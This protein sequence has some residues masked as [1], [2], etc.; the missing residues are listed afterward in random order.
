M[1]QRSR[2]YG[3]ALWGAALATCLGACSWIGLDGGGGGGGNV[4]TN[5]TRLEQEPNDSGD[6]PN[7]I[8]AGYPVRGDL[9]RLGDVDWFVIRLF[10]GHTIRVE[11]FATRLDQAD[12]DAAGTVPRVTMAYPF[13]DVKVIEHSF[14]DGWFHAA[15]DFEFPSYR[16][17]TTGT[18]WFRVSP[19]NELATGGRYALRVSYADASESLEIENPFDIGG[20]DSTGTAQAIGAGTLCGFHRDGND[21]F[22]SI[23]V[24]GPTVLRC[25]LVASRNGAQIG[26]TTYYD[27]TLRLFGPD[28][29]TQIAA[30]DDAF[31]SDPAI[32]IEVAAAGTYAIGVGEAPASAVDGY[33]KLLVSTSSASGTAE[34]EPNDNTGSADLTAYGQNVSGTI[35][36]GEEDWFRFAGTAGDMVRLQTFDAANSETAAEAVSVSLVAPDGTTPVATDR[37]P[38]F[39]VSS[40]ILPQSGTFFVHVTP[41]PGALAPTTYRLELRRLHASTFETEPNDTIAQAPWFS[42]GGFASGVIATIGDVD[43]YRFTASSGELV[44]F[45]AFAARSIGSD[46][47]LE[48]SGHGSDLLPLLTIRDVNGAVLATSTAIPVNGVFA[49]ALSD[50]LPTA[51]VAF[52]APPTSSVFHVQVA[53]ADN[54]GGADHRYVLQKR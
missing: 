34:T 25:E 22:Y 36:P 14:T 29:L 51:A 15:Q 13:S 6:T 47:Q 3:P 18:F 5:F 17:T 52:V 28:G 23:R 8:F 24:S 48:Y 54:S 39:Q 35:G 11:L 21:D 2:R 16:L 45:D 46:Q 50:S 1:S 31:L 12:W 9:L 49:E 33:Y 32:Q 20:N 7:E 27:P 26:E 4:V 41:D 40:A 43:T 44:V 10:A 37:G 42:S 19:D 38:L 53:A 30:N